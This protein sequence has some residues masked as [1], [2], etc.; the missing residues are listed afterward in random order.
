MGS[1]CIKVAT[2]HLQWFPEKMRNHLINKSDITIWSKPPVT[3]P[4]K[5]LFLPYE[6]NPTSSFSYMGRLVSWTAWETRTSIG[7]QPWHTQ[8]ILCCLECSRETLIVKCSLFGVFRFI[9]PVEKNRD[10]EYS[11]RSCILPLFSQ[12]AAAV[13]LFFPP[14]HVKNLFLIQTP[15]NSW[16]IAS[17]LCF[18]CVMSPEYRPGLAFIP[19]VHRAAMREVLG[20]FPDEMNV[21]PY[22]HAQRF[23][24]S[25]YGTCVFWRGPSLNH[26]GWSHFFPKPTVDRGLPCISCI[27]DSG[28]ECCLYLQPAWVSETLMLWVTFWRFH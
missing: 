3:V 17:V 4:L 23:N 25:S 6:T 8:H 28:T 15:G 9:E 26:C 11:V 20:G 10:K 27:Q 5:E 22:V 1:N 2:A 14:S 12:P 18:T 13:H 21:C 19:P 16:N 7:C 24:K